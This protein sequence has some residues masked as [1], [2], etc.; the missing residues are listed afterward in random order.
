MTARE[1]SERNAEKMLMLGPVLDRLRSE[2][3]QPLIERVYGIMDRAGKIAFPPPELAGQPIKVEFISILAQ[4]QKQA[5]L[6]AIDQLRARASLRKLPAT[7]RRW[8][9]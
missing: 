7:P 3:F 2:L 6:S 1:V 5:G 8:T 9:S 4:A